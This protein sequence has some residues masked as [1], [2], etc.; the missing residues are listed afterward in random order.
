M[1]GGAVCA[2]AAVVFN[3][4]RTAA[5]RRIRVGRCMVLMPDPNR[6]PERR[7]AGLA[8]RGAHRGACCFLRRHD[9]F[10]FE[11]SSG[12]SCHS[13]SPPRRTPL[14]ATRTQCV[15][16][17]RASRNYVSAAIGPQFVT[18]TVAAARAGRVFA[19][20]PASKDAAHLITIPPGAYTVEI[21]G[22]GDAERVA[23]LE[24]NEVP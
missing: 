8:P 16:P 17:R 4:A 18:I 5:V 10:R 20:P 2:C 14:Q 13:L 22:E 7:G 6:A 23:L 1:G 11:G 12:R 21:R 3:A 19:L 15:A 9:P 24:I